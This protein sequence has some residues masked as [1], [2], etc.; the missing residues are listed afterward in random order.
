MMQL[1][2]LQL[3]LRLQLGRGP[4]TGLSR[5]C[6][7]PRVSWVLMGFPTPVLVVA[8]LALGTTL[9]LVP[10]SDIQYP[11]KYPKKL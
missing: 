7:F 6:P 11:K 9:V 10:T 8:T 1:A 3:T 2:P 5:A 4:W